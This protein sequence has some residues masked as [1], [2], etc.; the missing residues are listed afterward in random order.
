MEWIQQLNTTI[1]YIEGH[2]NDG[3]ND[4]ALAKLADCS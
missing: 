2:L 3:I 1:N 4:E